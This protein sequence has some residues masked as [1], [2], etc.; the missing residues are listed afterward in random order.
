[1]LSI[2]GSA[3][4]GQSKKDRSSLFLLG[5][6][7]AG[8][9]LLMQTLNRLFSNIYVKEFSSNTFSKD[10]NKR[11]KIMNEFLKV[12]D[13]RICWVNEL[14]GKIDDSLFKSFCEGNVSQY[15]Y[16]KTV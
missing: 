8:K 9:S 14:S 6:S 16:I 1:M 5:K 13:C 2:I 3:I 10:N 15:R 12:K 7:S 11:D 4:T